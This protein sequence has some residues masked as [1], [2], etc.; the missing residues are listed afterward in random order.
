[1]NMNRKKILAFVLILIVLVG[2]FCSINVLADTREYVG[3][4]FCSE[5]STLKIFGVAGQ[6]LI[7]AKILVPLIIIVLAI[8]DMYKAV[9]GK[10][11]KEIVKQTK[12]IALRVVLG[13]FIFFIPTL[14]HWVI[15]LI[16]QDN[17]ENSYKQCFDCVLS[18]ID[19]CN[20]S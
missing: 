3:Q 14:T 5:S 17:P 19:N 18:P 11:E 2:T 9:I 1:M 16:Y 4:N 15:D 8:F 10:D 12:V 20:N 13:V 6:I 7:I